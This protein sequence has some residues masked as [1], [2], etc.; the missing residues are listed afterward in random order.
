MSGFMRIIKTNSS[1]FV[2]TTLQQ[3]QFAWQEGYG[4]FSVS[5]SMLPTVINYIERQEEHHRKGSFQD[6][7]LMLL[8]KHGIDYDARYVFG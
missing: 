8:K 2:R 7:Y 5:V 3:D 4:I 6:E 1:R